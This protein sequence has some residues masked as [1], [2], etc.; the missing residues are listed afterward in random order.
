MSVLT[1]AV[2]GGLVTELICVT[3]RVPDRGEKFTSSSFSRQAGGEGA[4]SAVAAAR[5]SRVNPHR[6]HENSQ[7]SKIMPNID[8]RV[9][10]VGAVGNDDF[11]PLLIEQL[12][13]NSVDTTRVQTINEMSTGVSVVMVES[14]FGDSRILYNPGANHVLRPED[15]LTLESLAGGVKP[16][17][18]ISMLEIRRD[19]VEQIIQTANEENIDILLS[20]LPAQSLLDHIYK[21]ITHLV[22]NKTAAAMLIGKELED[23]ADREGWAS[24]ADEFLRWGIANVII[25]LGDQGAYFSNDPGNGGYVAAEIVA[26]I[27]DTPG[28]G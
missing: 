1:I 13:S 19:T 21:M 3:D 18:I 12:Q 15:F 28:A 24:V 5:L 6:L 14:D 2:I 25:T 4:N 20:L 11:G 22:V 8:I 17:L 9:S 10:M 23:I 7:P 16:D 27:K 26:D